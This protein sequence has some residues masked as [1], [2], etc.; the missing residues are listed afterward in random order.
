MMTIGSLKN[1]KN[2]KSL[3]ECD[4]FD[5]IKRSKHIREPLSEFDI[6]DL[7]DKFLNN[8]FHYIAV[9]N[10]NFGRS[11]ID[12]FVHSLH[13]YHDNAILTIS[14]PITG[15]CVIDLY[16]ELLQGG[17]TSGG[18]DIEEFFIDQFYYDF[19]CIEACHE[20]V[21]QRWFI[22]FFSQL[23]HFKLNKHIPILVIS[24]SK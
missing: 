7:Q 8:G 19:L 1:I 24:Y 17:Y 20:L 13:C 4:I 11:L 3:F 21:D 5:D 16:Y 22:H 12:R 14:S 18:R 6:L 10:I 2:K 23:L 15:S 9:N